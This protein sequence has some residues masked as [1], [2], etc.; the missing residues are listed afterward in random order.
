MHLTTQLT[1]LVLPVTHTLICSL[2]LLLQAVSW[3]AILESY[4]NSV[5]LLSADTK[6]LQLML[7]DDKLNIMDVSNT[8]ELFGII[9]PRNKDRQDNTDDPDSVS[10]SHLNDDDDDDESQV[11]N[12]SENIKWYEHM[13]YHQVLVDKAYAA[14]NI[15]IRP[16]NPDAELLLFFNYKHKP[17]PDLYER[18]IPLRI[19]REQGLWMNGSYNIF[20]GNDVINNRTGFF[21]LGIAEVDREV[22]ESS[23]DSYLLHDIIINENASLANYSAYQSN[24][25]LPGLMRNYTTD[26][27][28]DIYTSGC[29]FFDYKQKIWSGEGCYVKEANS[30]LTYCKCNH[31]TSFGSG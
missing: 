6:T 31:L 24:Y 10:S 23:S 12:P 25:S 15:E 13:V 20:L 21:Y 18:L 9:V 16:S 2:T 3:P 8:S 30:S 19:A 28:L 22:L 29:Y 7:L 5:D 11:I 4:G 1:P 17:L 26:Y 27:R 14:V